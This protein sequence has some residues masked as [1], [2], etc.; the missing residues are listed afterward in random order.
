MV[1][2]LVVLFILII[3]IAP[4]TLAYDLSDFPNFLKNKVIDTTIIVGENAAI[5]DVISVDEISEFFNNCTHTTI[6]EAKICDYPILGQFVSSKLTNEVTNLAT[7]NIISI[8]G[9]CANKITAQIM[10]LPTTWPEC[11]AGFEEGKG[12]IKLFNKWNKTQI[13]V[14]GYSA[15]DTK[16]TAKVLAK[17]QESDLTGYEIKVTGNII[18]PSLEKVITKEERYCEKDEDC[19]LVLSGC[20]NCF[21]CRNIG[22]T[23]PE[24]IAVN[25]NLYECPPRPK[26]VACIACVGAIGY[27]PNEDAICVNNKCEKRE[28]IETEE[29]VYGIFYNSQCYNDNKEKFGTSEISFKI[30]QIKNV[31]VS[32]TDK[33]YE[34]DEGNLT[35]INILWYQEQVPIG[36]DLLTAYSVIET[37][38][39]TVW[40]VQGGIFSHAEEGGVVVGGGTFYG[41][42][43]IIDKYSSRILTEGWYGYG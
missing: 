37:L 29:R 8:G 39:A 22:L 24:V 42:L 20:P 11:A 5:D 36:D 30:E 28:V 9:P 14:A 12:M 43:V 34:T 1:K 38:N 17:S 33:I 18:N 40:R 4:F 21:P 10:D 15:E 13:I 3:A 19:I 32:K 7:Q 26:D 6:P 41:C 27:D 16:K 23:D 25:K 2:R 35:S 31:S